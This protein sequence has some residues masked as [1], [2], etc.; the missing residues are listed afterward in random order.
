MLA[1]ARHPASQPQQHLVQLEKV[2]IGKKRDLS[3]RYRPK[4][5]VVKQQPKCTEAQSLVTRRRQ[6]YADH[7]LDKEHVQQ[8]LFLDWCLRIDN[9]AVWPAE[10]WAELESARACIR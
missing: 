10:R 1:S 3:H 2:L 4:A 5:S 8:A 6:K 7:I 9:D